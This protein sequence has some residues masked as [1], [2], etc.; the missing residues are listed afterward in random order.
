MK[1]VALLLLL[2]SPAF[3]Q[4]RFEVSAGMTWTGGFGAGGTDAQLSRPSAPSTPLTLF[5][6]S[7]RMEAA[8]GFVGR[9]TFHF[10]PHFGA[11]GAVEFS[12]PRLRTTISDDFE[13]AT[14]TEADMVVS[15]YGFGGS[16]VYR[17]GEGRLV[18]FALAGAGR[19]RQL[20]G[21]NVNLVTAMELHAGGGL[22]YKLAGHVS[23]RGDA[24]VSSRE[25][26]LTFDRKR[27]TLPVLAASLCYRF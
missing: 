15:S 7:S 18:P 8:A 11:E 25:K 21:D 1:V 23:I 16:L 26:S 19:L 13:N 27:S 17:F 2:A 5:R 10:T 22:T 20:D 14:G 4:S 24:V 9:A 3:A 6:T 12:R